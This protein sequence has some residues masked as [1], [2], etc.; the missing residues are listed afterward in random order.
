M[1]AEPSSPAFRKVLALLIISTG[2]IIVLGSAFASPQKEPKSPYSAA[3]SG[4]TLL[5]IGLVFYRRAASA[6]N[7][8]AARAN[9]LDWAVI[10]IMPLPLHR[11]LSVQERRLARAPRVAHLKC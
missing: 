6:D 1:A 2:A 5:G 3:L 7:K 8:P 9:A 11:T 4:L 10:S